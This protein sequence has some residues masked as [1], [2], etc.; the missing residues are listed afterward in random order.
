LTQRLP[1]DRPLASSVVPFKARIPLGRF[2]MPDEVAEAVCFRLSDAA[3]AVNGT[4]LPIDAGF[5]A[6]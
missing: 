6:G 4:C 5:L 2:V 3:S 1:P